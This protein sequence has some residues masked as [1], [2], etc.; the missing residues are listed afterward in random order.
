MPNT[1][2]TPTPTSSSSAEDLNATFN[3]HISNLSPQA[4]TESMRDLA[5]GCQ[6]QLWLPDENRR[7]NIGAEPQRVDDSGYWSGSGEDASLTTSSLATSQA[8]GA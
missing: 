5:W 8:S 6:A 7:R 4:S 2:T 3:R 1:A